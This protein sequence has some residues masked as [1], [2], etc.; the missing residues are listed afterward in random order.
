MR[1]KGPTPRA[2]GPSLRLWCPS[3]SSFLGLVRDVAKHMAVMAGF[4]DTTAGKVA[5]A[6]DE[7][8]ANAIEHAYHGDPGHLVELRIEY[9][10]EV[11]KA[12]VVDTG[13]RIDPKAVP[14]FELRKYVNERRTGG[15]G[16]HLMAKIMDSVTF[17]RSARENVCCLVKRKEPNE[18][19]TS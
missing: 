9:R 16:V 14:E 6:V 17:H 4:D 2:P 18:Q 12:E 19:T 8:T 7:A 10:G 5:L 13:D 3:E 15:L 1:G 11:F